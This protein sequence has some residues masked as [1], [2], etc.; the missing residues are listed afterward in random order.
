[1]DG[2]GRGDDSA[3][4]ETSM[5]SACWQPAISGKPDLLPPLVHRT[6]PS[7]SSSPP[8]PSTTRSN[9]KPAVGVLQLVIHGSKFSRQLAKIMASWITFVGDRTMVDMYKFLKKHA[10][11]PFNSAAAAASC[12][13]TSATNCLGE[14]Y[15]SVAPLVAL[16]L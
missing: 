3:V 2:R 12:A 11:I 10:A 5:A 16:D 14:L 6:I 1:M 13:S 15:P 7:T 8:T 9:F 4:A